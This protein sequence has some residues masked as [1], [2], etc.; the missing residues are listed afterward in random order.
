MITG[1]YDMVDAGGNVAEASHQGKSL[2]HLAI[3]YSNFSVPQAADQAEVIFWNLKC[4]EQKD[5]KLLF[6]SSWRVTLEAKKTHH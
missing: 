3:H 4:L 5:S 6:V 2:K 1:Q